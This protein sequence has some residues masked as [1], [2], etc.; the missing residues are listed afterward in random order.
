MEMTTGG[1]GRMHSPEGYVISYA[2]YEGMWFSRYNEEED[3]A[4]ARLMAQAPTLAQ[5]VLNQAAEI[6]RLKHA[7]AVYGAAACGAL[8]NHDQEMADELFSGL[9]AP[10]E[11]KPHAE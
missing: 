4:N 6:E 10:L 7:I 9:V 1:Y 11:E 3:T 5:T 2:A 8:R